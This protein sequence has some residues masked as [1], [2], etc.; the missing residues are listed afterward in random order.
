MFNI[1]SK[2]NKKRRELTTQQDYYLEGIDYEQQ[3]ERWIHSD[4]RKSLTNYLSAFMT[5]E[6]GISLF[7]GNGDRKCEYD[8]KFNMT[9]ISLVIYS[10]YICNDYGMNLLK[11]IDLENS[12]LDLNK[13]VIPLPDIIKNF[14]NVY[15]EYHDV[16]TWDF[17]YNLITS[18]LSYIENEEM[19]ENIS[20]EE[21]DSITEKM[22]MILNELIVTIQQETIQYNEAI[23]SIEQKSNEEEMNDNSFKKE[24]KIED[25][26][27]EYMEVSDTV[28]NDT[29]PEVLC[30]GY[31]YIIGVFERGIFN[32][33][34]VN[35]LY[36]ALNTI[37]VHDA[38]VAESESMIE[39]S[40]LKEQI[41]GMGLYSHAFETQEEYLNRLSKVDITT[42]TLVIEFFISTI[43][44][45][46]VSNKWKLC[47]QLNKIYNEQLK[48]NGLQI[49]YKLLLMLNLLENE[50]E[51]CKLSAFLKMNEKTTH[52]LE[53]NCLTMKNNIIKLCDMPSSVDKLNENIIKKLQRQ[54]I[55]DQATELLS[56]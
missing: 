52:I 43:G 32:N 16:K 20:M 36:S 37:E 24:E 14:E 39:L 42:T 33:E 28:T 21:L 23:A 35:Q 46:D 45:D 27:D 47:T 41:N 18:Y 56:M 4:I 8:I 17:D 13:I 55:K 30:I 54:Y 2:K 26:S 48:N 50:I 34:K 44:D 19:Y 5:Y 9:R 7:K 40:K 12:T 3:G 51:R 29:L 22:L 1:N 15:T 10:E 38:K 11:Y 25:E 53:K 31:K 49:M 6:K